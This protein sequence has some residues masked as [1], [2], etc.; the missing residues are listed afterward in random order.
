[1]DSSK[2]GS[3]R[4]RWTAKQRQRLL[5]RFHRSQLTLKQFANGRGVGLST[6]SKWLR[7]ER[8]AGE[9]IVKFREVVFPKAASHWPM[10]VVNPQ[11]W[12]LRLAQTPEV[13]TLQQLL[14][15]LP[16]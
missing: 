15:A 13:Q 9:P 1:M 4:R 12:I 5:A 10:E 14:Q 7:L 6:L 8:D 2:T 16:C 3:G 11:G